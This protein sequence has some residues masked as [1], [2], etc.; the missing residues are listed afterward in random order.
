MLLDSAHLLDVLAVDPND[1]S[2]DI[3]CSSRQGQHLEASSHSRGQ[4]L[5]RS[6]QFQAWITKGS[7]GS[8]FVDDAAHA[9][10]Q[11]ISIM[12]FACAMILDSLQD[13]PAIP[14][15]HFCGLHTAHDDPLQ[16]PSGMMRALLAQL[17]RAHSFHVGFSDANKYHQLQHFSLKRL[18]DLLVDTIRQL[19]SDV[20]LFCVVDGPSLLY[21]KQAG[22]KECQFILETLIFLTQDLKVEA[23][24]KV[25]VTNP[26]INRYPIEH[27][28]SEDHLTLRQGPLKYDDV[29]LTRRQIMMQ[30]QRVSD[31]GD[32]RLWHHPPELLPSSSTEE[33]DEGFVDGDDQHTFEGGDFEEDLL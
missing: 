11:R 33:D 22:M 3:E 1:Y 26:M 7:S 20:V 21:D 14:I 28:H 31:E 2:H 8:L 23:V 19:P 16:G 32:R 17:L 5:I 12:T 6:A 27:L 4:Q 15:H 13:E 18:C 24:F 30:S 10:P 29:A 9:A 25:L